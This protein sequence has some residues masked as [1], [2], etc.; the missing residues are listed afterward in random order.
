MKKN[1]QRL[2]E[3]STVVTKRLRSIKDNWW[4]NKSEQIQQ[5][6]DRRQH[7]EFY[8]SL[9]TIFGPCIQTTNAVTDLDS[10]TVHTNSDEVMSVWRKH[11]N[12][13][14]NRSAPVDWSAVDR[15][16]Q[17]PMINTLSC[18]PDM[19]EIEKAIQQ[20]CN[21]KSAGNDGL[22][23][24]LFKHGGAALNQSVLSLVQS[25]WESETIP[26]EFKN[27]IIVPLYKGK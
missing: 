17:Q 1:K 23:A 15:L 13:L 2:L 10:G 12:S 14:L 8:A 19:S 18:V 22:P 7:K 24:E 4:K 11:F 16:P 21:G 6:A 20:L 9:K 3:A 27:A 25:I 26:Q 5:Y